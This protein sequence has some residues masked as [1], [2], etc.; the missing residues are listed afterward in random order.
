PA[1]ER[2]PQQQAAPMAPVVKRKLRRRP[3]F[4]RVAGR[5]VIAVML[6]GLV[7]LGYAQATGAV[8]VSGYLALLDRL[9][10]LPSLPGMP[11]VAVGSERASLRE[12]GPS[13]ASQPPAAGKATWRTRTDQSGSSGKPE[14]VV[15][16]DVQV[17]DQQIDLTVSFSRN[18]EADGGLSH[19]FE[20]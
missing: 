9:P 18:A 2:P 13:A 16:L 8:D 6:L 20:F 3:I 17:P 12:A 10:S 14:T 11:G 15:Q 5:L 7:A 4:G 1:R 19:L